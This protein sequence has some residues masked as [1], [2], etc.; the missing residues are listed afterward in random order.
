MNDR[1]GANKNWHTRR[2]FM[3]A[4]SAFCIWVVTYILLRDKDTEAAKTAVE[5]SFW[6][7]LGITGSYVF[8]ATW[9]DLN[10][11]KFTGK[12]SAPAKADPDT[13]RGD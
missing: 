11:M 6:T 2:R 13:K 10:K 7:L 3:F 5:M 9:D 1:N 8:G 4:V 12:G